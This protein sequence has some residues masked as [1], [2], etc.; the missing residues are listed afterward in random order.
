M[1]TVGALAD[2]L[3]N[4]NE[5]YTAANKIADDL[6]AEKTA[7]ETEIIMALEAQGIDGAQ[8]KHG[9]ITVTRSAKPQIEDYDAFTAF[10]LRKKAPYLFERRVSLKGYNEMKESMKGKPIPGIKEFIKV[11]L[12]V[13]KVTKE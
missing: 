9:K 1:K 3:Y 6:K 11:G 4:L 8:G 10:I 7:L 13:R 12:S 2:E 5:K